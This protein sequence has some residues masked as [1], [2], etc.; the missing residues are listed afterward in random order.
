MRI[1]KKILSSFFIVLLFCQCCQA[2]QLCDCFGSCVNIYLRDVSAHIKKEVRKLSDYPQNIRLDVD[3][4]VPLCLGG[5]NK[6][7]N[8]QPLSKKD[9]ELKTR[10]DLLLLY[11]VNNCLMTIQEAQEAA[12]KWE[13]KLD[14]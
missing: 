11:F 1:I 14:K 5:S 3:H 12:Y 4:K 10:N 8:L 2:R 7:E 6:I 9:H 13:R